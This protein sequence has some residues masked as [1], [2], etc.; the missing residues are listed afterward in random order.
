MLTYKDEIVL[1]CLTFTPRRST[2]LQRMTGYTD[3]EVRDS[4][5]NLRLNGLAVCSGNKGFWLWNGKDDSWRHTKNN[6]KSRAKKLIELY[7]AMED[8]PIVGQVEL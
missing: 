5:R 8:R 4:I 3:I 1:N 6:I 7:N 2:E